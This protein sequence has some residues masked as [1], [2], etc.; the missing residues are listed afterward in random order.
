MLN[1]FIYS[2][3][4]IEM[5]S[6]ISNSAVFSKRFQSL[7]RWVVVVVLWL[8]IGSIAIGKA[9]ISNFMELIS[10]KNILVQT[11]M[12]LE[13]Q[14]QELEQTIARLKSSPSKQERYLKQ[15]FGYVEQ[16]E[17]IFQ[18]NTK[19]SFSFGAISHNSPI[20]SAESSR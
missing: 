4:G 12:E 6:P 18:F 3:N 13:I 20:F 10:E 9:G 15:N 17:Y 2:M 7:A 11:N 1:T 5:S 16:D 14:N 8:I 19:N